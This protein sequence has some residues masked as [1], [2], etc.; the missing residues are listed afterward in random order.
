MICREQIAT[1]LISIAKLLKSKIEAME[2]PKIKMHHII[3][4]QMTEKRFHLIQLV[5]K[6]L[7]SPRTQIIILT[8]K[9]HTSDEL[10]ICLNLNGFKATSVNNDKRQKQNNRSVEKF[11]EAQYDILVTSNSDITKVPPQVKH[12]INFD[13]FTPNVMLYEASAPEEKIYVF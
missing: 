6:L 10:S 9:N 5:G 4:I 13:M 2:T 1:F 8:G 11:N 3:Q 12:L 7:R